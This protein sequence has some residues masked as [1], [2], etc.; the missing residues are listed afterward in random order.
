MSGDLASW[1]RS[2]SGRA[3]CE[4]VRRE[5]AIKRAG[6]GGERKRKEEACE[7]SDRKS[8]AGDTRPRRVC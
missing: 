1:L 7:E 2:M 3:S 6:R 4:R 8:T 5:A